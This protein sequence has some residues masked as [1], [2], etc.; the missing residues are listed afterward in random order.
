MPP[1]SLPILRV[2]L[3]A[4]LLLGALACAAVLGSRV[5]NVAG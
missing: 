1:R 4:A 3:L 2:L 5:A